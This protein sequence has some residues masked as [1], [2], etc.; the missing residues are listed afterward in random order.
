MM[1]QEVLRNVERRIGDE[2]LYHELKETGNAC[3]DFEQRIPVVQA[4]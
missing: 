4:T 2:D 3:T 1:R